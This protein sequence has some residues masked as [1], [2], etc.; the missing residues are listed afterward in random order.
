MISGS[1]RLLRAAILVGAGLSLCGC[2]TIREAVGN[3]K[4]APDEFAVVTKAPL[5]I[6][7]DYNLR[8]PK[9]GAPPENQVEPTQAAQQSLFGADTATIASSIPGNM[10]Q[11]EKLLLA[12]AGAQNA[13]P[14][15]RQTLASDQNKSIQSASDSFT[16]SVLF[17]QKPAVANDP[18]LDADAEAKRISAQG[19]TKPAG[20]DAAAS[21]STPK[22][23]NDDQTSIEKKKKSSGWFDW[24]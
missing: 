20:T 6:P 9:P 12:N 21:D 7:P 19:G 18:A 23:A 14:A 13:D 5:I 2:D 16:N 11:G 10:S 17:W 3:G 8:P 1:G 4:E 15:I 22:P 24:F